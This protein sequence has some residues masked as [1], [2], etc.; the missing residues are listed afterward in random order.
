MRI[1]NFINGF[2]TY[3]SKLKD[4]LLNFKTRQTEISSELN[5]VID[6]DVLISDT[7]KNL[8]KI[9]KELGLEPN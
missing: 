1:N 3:I 9:D 7:N 8:E 2:D 5:N 4:N 6:Y